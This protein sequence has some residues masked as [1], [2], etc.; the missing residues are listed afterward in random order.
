LIRTIVNNPNDDTKVSLIYISDTQENLYFKDELDSY[1]AKYSNIR[2]FY[3]LTHVCILLHSTHTTKANSN[4]KGNRGEVTTEI[5]KSEFKEPRNSEQLRVIVCGSPEMIV[6]TIRS[7]YDLNY[8]SDTIFVF[9]PTGDEYVK[10]VY[11]R[12]APLTI[13][14]TQRM[15]F[16]V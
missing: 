16:V 8:P 11:G 4:W 10:S 2:V 12:S 5:I 14:T 9:G 13:H 3:S 15:T 6:T 1:V 7:L